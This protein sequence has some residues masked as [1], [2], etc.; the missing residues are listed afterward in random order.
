[1]QLVCLQLEASCLQWSFSTYNSVWEH[2]L[3]TIGTSLLATAAFL[4]T[5]ETFYLQLRL[6]C[7]QWEGAS[8]KHLHGL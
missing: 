1:M 5:I 4:L 6:F 2:F 3:L 7:L 8:N